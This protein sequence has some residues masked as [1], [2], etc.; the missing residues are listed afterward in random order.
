MGDETRTI[1]LSLLDFDNVIDNIAKCQMEEFTFA[2][3]VMNLSTD[4]LSI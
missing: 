1:Q 3:F 4:D 2:L